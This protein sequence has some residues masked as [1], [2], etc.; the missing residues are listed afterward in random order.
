MDIENDALITISRQVPMMKPALRRIADYM[1]KDQENI[2]FM[3]ISEL[4]KMCSVSVGTVTRF[5]KTTGFESF[6]KLKI[7]LAENQIRNMQRDFEAEGRGVFADLVETD[8]TERIIQK[9]TY[10][11]VDTI[12]NTAKYL[13]PLEI[14]KAVS[15]IDRAKLIVIYCVG[16]SKVAGINAKLRF[17]RLGKHCLLYSDPAEQVSSST[18][19][20]RDAL[21]LGI[22]SS[23]RTIPTVKSIEMAK[24]CGA[25]TICITSSAD[26][27]IVKH[28]DINFFTYAM[29]S[30]FFQES[31]VSRISQSVI[32]DILYACLVIRHY[33]ESVDKITKSA[34][35]MTSLYKLL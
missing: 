34:K 15:A 22:S 30:A 8:S 20:D 12:Q 29:E 19:F 27:P 31:L 18:L 23:G 21:A 25:T 4:A 32:I 17:Y 9:I 13:S 14:E 28:S 10:A 6:Q 35:I 1:L 16:S 2:K 5:V 3:S 24:K 33:G 7:A 26:S 11:N